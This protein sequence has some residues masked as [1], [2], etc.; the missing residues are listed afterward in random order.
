MNI[1]NMDK[2]QASI[3]VNGVQ[4]TLEQAK[5]KDKTY[6]A[7]LINPKTKRIN[8]IEFGASKYEQFKDSTPLKLY[9]NKDHNNLERRKRYY[10]R[11]G[12]NKGD[13]LSKDW[14]AKKFLW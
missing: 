7:T 12:E 3:K 14:F 8:N 13:F 5:N 6:R 4:I 2:K 1:I 10:Q 9:L 11:H